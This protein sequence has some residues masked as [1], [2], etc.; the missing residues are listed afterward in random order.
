MHL[1]PR[2]YRYW[3]QLIRAYLPISQ[4]S[5][6]QHASTDEPPAGTSSAPLVLHVMASDLARGGQAET[7]S[8]CDALNEPTELHRA[9]TLFDNAEG[10]LRAEY[11]LGVTS[12][13]FRA[14]GFDPRALIRLNR[15]LAR[16]QPQLIVA[17]GSEALKYLALTRTPANRLVYH[18][19]GIA[20][21]SAASGS[22]A[23]IPPLVS[24]P[25]CSRRCCFTRRGG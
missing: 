11:R 6:K 21:A 8:I 15:A 18:R 23:Q 19:I 22:A 12:G 2:N 13:R 14:L 7:R 17:H 25:L 24:S 20:A 9:M 16:K 5:V 1:T 3:L 4:K 10:N